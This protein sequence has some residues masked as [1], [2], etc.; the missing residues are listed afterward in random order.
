MKRIFLQKKQNKT[1]LELLR[2]QGEY[3]DAPCSGKGTCGKC[4]III[5]ET[6][7]TDP[8]KQ[9][10]KEVF[11][12]RELEEGWRLSCMTVP[13]DDLYVC[14]PEIR[15][16][17]IQVQME[18]VRNTKMESDVQATTVIC[19]NKIED[20]AQIGSDGEIKPEN[21][22]TEKSVYGIAIDIGTTTLAA[23]L[24]SLTDG[25]CLKTASSV[26]HQRAYGADVISRIRAAAS[27]DAE[28]LRE[29][30]LKDV[31][32]LAETLLAG[33]DENVLNVSKIVIAGNTTMIH[34]LLGYSCVGLG[35]AP[36]TPVN[37]APEDMTWGELNGEYE[38]TRESGDA[39]ES[40]VA[41]DGS[42][43]REHGYVRECGHTGIN[44]TTKV[45]IM[46][47]ISAFVG[48][49]I[50]AGMM[51]CGMRPDKCEMLID[52]GTNGEMV[53]AA[54]DHFLVSS[55]A[56]GPAFEGGNISCGMPGVPGAVCRAVLFGK[57]NMV[58]KTIGNKPAI[59]LCGTGIIDVMY[60]LVRHH[61]VDTQGILGEPWFEKGFPV[62]PGKIYFTQ[63]DIRQ[64]QMAKAAI[65][66]GLEVLLQKSNI[67]Y[68]QIK[69]VYVAGGF[70]MGLDMEKALG[71]GLLPIG[72]RGK[73]TPV[74]NSALEGAARCLTHSKESSDMQ[75]QEIAAISHEINL[76]DT[77][78]FQELY[79][80]HMQFC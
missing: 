45:Q 64:V 50:T 37:L 78:E 42:D 14:I 55:V 26:N 66:A 77:P 63:E 70:G 29:S 25:I 73:L 22:D 40:G 47:G 11:T 10:E 51:G 41:R 6:R 20:R 35:A 44:Q 72:L 46:P 8:P 24:I 18:F 53:L 38:E 39:K 19:E 2:E 16:N 17:Q 33:Q 31:R 15:E 79:L 69:K 56:A 5:E 59:G 1:I 80:K 49:D 12:E 62:V 48:G 43:A 52:I 4:C 67:S 60:E 34:L 32:N 27:G 74:G 76:A 9:R 28:K 54:G 21:M 68:E 57:N 3:L 36:F 61:I 58:T 13:T 71:I 75:P 7:K 30:I 23:E 65:C